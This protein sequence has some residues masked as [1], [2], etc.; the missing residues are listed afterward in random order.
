MIDTSDAGPATGAALC[1]RGGT[2][3]E[4]ASGPVE[5][6]DLLFVIDDSMSMGEE[7]DAV[8]AALPRLGVL[9][10]QPR[11]DGLAVHLAV[12]TVPGSGRGHPLQ[13]LLYRVVTLALE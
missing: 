6:V 5:N 3:S 11:T 12:S 13:H 7:Q 9:R 8:S 4:V 10:H 2:C 1:S